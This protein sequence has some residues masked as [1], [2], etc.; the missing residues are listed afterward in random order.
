MFEQR[1]K[2]FLYIG[3]MVVAGR[4]SYV[5]VYMRRTLYS[6]SLSLFLYLWLERQASPVPMQESRSKSNY[7][8]LWVLRLR[9]YEQFGSLDPNRCYKLV[10]IA[11]E[12]KSKLALRRATESD[13]ISRRR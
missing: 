10:Q 2:L 7:P 11:A 13:L 8:A 5:G 1:L 4:F 9:E 3:E 6:L 12:K